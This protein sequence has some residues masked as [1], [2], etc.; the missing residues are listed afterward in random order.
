VLTDGMLEIGHWRALG[1]E[2]AEWEARRK[3]SR[4]KAEQERETWTIT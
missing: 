1:R 2:H 3:L 4:H